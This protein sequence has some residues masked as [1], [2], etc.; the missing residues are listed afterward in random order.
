MVLL[1]VEGAAPPAPG[2]LKGMGLFADTP[3]KAENSALAYVG[4]CTEQN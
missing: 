2:T 3:T 1:L 4:R